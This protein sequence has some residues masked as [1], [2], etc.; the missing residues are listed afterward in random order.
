MID[1]YDKHFK[2]L[3]KYKRDTTFI[4]HFLFKDLRL[5]NVKWYI[6]YSQFL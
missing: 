1:L 6:E 4:K 5:N 2:I 3:S